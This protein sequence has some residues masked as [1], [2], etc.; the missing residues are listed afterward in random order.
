M[1]QKD[2]KIFRGFI[3]NPNSDLSQIEHDLCVLLYLNYDKLEKTSFRLG[4]RQKC[5][6]KLIRENIGVEL[7]LPENNQELGHEKSIRKL[8]RIKVKSFRGFQEEQS[9]DFGDHFTFIYGRNGTGKSSLVDAIEFSLLDN[10]QEAKYKRI[11]VKEYIKNIYTQSGIQPILYGSTSDGT[12]SKITA[13]SDKYDFAVIERNRIE[14]FARISAETASIQQQRLA[15]LVGLDSWNTFVNNFSKDI[16]NFLPYKDELSEQIANQKTELASYKDQL[17]ASIKSVKDSNQSLKDLFKQFGQ[18]D[19]DSLSEYLNDQ[20]KKLDKELSEI[21]NVSMVSTKYITIIKETQ[22]Q[23]L[24][25]QGEYYIH[26]NELKNYKDNLSLVDLANAILS[27]KKFQANNCPACQS[28]ILDDQGE[29]MVPENPYEYATKIQRQFSE[30]TKLEKR[31][32]NEKVALEQ[33]LRKLAN[34]L[35]MSGDNLQVAELQEVSIINRLKKAI[36]LFFNQKVPISDSTWINEHEFS[37]IN[38]AIH[39]H[40]ELDAK[41]KEEKKLLQS[42]LEKINKAKG[43][44]DTV[45]KTI[46][47]ASNLQEN[48]KVKQRKVEENQKNLEGKSNLAKKKNVPLKEYAE[49]YRSVVEKLKKYTELLPIAELSDL[50]GLTLKVYNLINKYDF[51]CE[52]ITYL[53]LPVSPNQGIIVKFNVPGSPLVDA[54]DVLSEGH[55]RTLGLSIL[56]AKALKNKQPFIIF[57]DVVNAIDD[58]HRKAIAEIITDLNG[59]FSNIQWIVTT[60]GQEFAKQLI[61]STCLSLR[62]GIKEIT[63]KEKELGSDIRAIE[64]SQDYLLLAKQKLEEEDIR[65]C[66]ADCRR[67]VEVLMIKLWKLYNKRFHSKISIEVDPSRPIPGTRNVMEVLRKQFKKQ[68]NGNTSELEVM[69][70]ILSK[71]DLLL[72]SQGISWFLLNKGTHEEEEAEQH[73]HVET[74]KILKDLLIPLNEELTNGV[75]VKGSILSR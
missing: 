14:N 12:E 52:Q 8:S 48:L 3:E 27:Q 61:S 10:I 16:D 21:G 41:N 62:K 70:T 54:L 71:L 28:Q 36:E 32:K 56:L 51:N 42:K 60:H 20:K 23:I 44:L 11:D 74:A 73:D 9:F 1:A 15:A 53:K 75:K 34:L 37:L 63:F 67:E 43:V 35:Q 7:K 33:Q 5:I 46:K 65:G 25:N 59:D 69:D 26:R 22:I 13:D 30:A 64:K 40:D 18:S 29:L 39:A 66:L 55:I 17:V 31:I 24:K 58:E 47:T 6:V 57:D 19:I 38:K 50:N 4:I 45:K 49:A 72:D 2:L 68:L